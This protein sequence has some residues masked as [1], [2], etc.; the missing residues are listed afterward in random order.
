MSIGDI[1]M[2]HSVEE[3]YLKVSVMNLKIIELH[4]E[5]YKTQ[6]S[7]DKAKCTFLLADVR[8]LAGEVQY[9]LVDLDIEFSKSSI[10]S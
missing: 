8:A 4:R 3:L 2:A 10:D 5:R 1:D 6:G 7:Y 9:G